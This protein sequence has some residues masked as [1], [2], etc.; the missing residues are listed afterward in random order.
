[1]Q[2]LSRAWPDELGARA[3]E[4]KELSQLL[5]QDHDLSVLGAF[6]QA[7]AELLPAA[8]VSAVA[9]QVR[10]F[11]EQLRVLAGLRGARLF[12]EG[13]QELTERLST[14][15]AAARKIAS[16]LADEPTPS[17]APAPLETPSPAGPAADVTPLRPSQ[18]KRATA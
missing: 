10:Q 5:G 8:A 15:W 4:A 11:Q 3:S 16:A 2:L 17:G 6:V 7:N 9:S 14:Y 13:P 18:R 12:A 1:M